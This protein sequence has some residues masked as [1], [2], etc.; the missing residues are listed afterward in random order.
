LPDNKTCRRRPSALRGFVDCLVDDPSGCH[1]ALK[2]KTGWLCLRPEGDATVTRKPA[3]TLFAL[4]FRFATRNDCPLLGR[5]NYQLI[6]DVGLP[7]HL[8]VSRMVQRMRA[9]L[10]SGHRA[11]LFELGGKVVGYA[12]YRESADHIYLRQFLVVRRQRHQG[13]GRCA[14][15]ILR[16][17]V[18]PV[19]KRLTVEVL[20]A[21]SSALEFWR[22]VGY[23]DHSLRLEIPPLRE[24]APRPT[25]NK[26]TNASSGARQGRKRRPR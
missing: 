10:A 6:H 20:V 24:R 4:T 26:A 23:T 21:N 9:L 12:L 19:V 1:H 14:V 5:L 8:T 3:G 11:V 15:A 17:Q 13:I 16:S 7:H 25:L 2:H 22:R 18:W